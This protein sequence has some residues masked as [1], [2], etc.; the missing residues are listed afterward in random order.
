MSNGSKVFPVLRL[1]QLKCMNRNCCLSVSR[2]H[3]MNRRPGSVYLFNNT[4]G[5]ATQMERE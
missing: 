4:W 3:L 5:L 2:R 1:A